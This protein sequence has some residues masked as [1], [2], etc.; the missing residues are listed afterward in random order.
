[1][2][3]QALNAMLLA[4]AGAASGE[5]VASLQHVMQLGAVPD[6]W[7]PDGSSVRIAASPNHECHRCSSR[8]S[9][10]WTALPGR[11][12]AGCPAIRLASH[13]LGCIALLAAMCAYNAAL[14][15]ST[16]AQFVLVR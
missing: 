1:V 9:V 2:P 16:L 7:A 15:G 4:C 3:W 6:T 8:G 10:N 14:G 13:A 12:C 11:D 5:A